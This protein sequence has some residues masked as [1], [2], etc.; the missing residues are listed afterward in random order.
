[1]M[2]SGVV[3]LDAI[4]DQLHASGVV[5]GDETVGFLAEAGFTAPTQTPLP[6]VYSLV[7]AVKP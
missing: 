7:T 3:D 6:G 1:M 5:S 4:I 2:A